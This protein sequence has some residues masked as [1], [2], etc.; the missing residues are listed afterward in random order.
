VVDGSRESAAGKEEAA[1]LKFV[2][3]VKRRAIRMAA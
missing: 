1:L 3:R 2:A